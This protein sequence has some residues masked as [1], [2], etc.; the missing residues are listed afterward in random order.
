MSVTRSTFL[1]SALLLA[2]LG[3]CDR[4]ADLKTA[5]GDCNESGCFGC[6]DDSK[7]ACWPLPYEPCDQAGQ[8]KDGAVCTNHGCATVCKADADC[9]PAEKCTTDGFCAPT[10]AATHPMTPGTTQTCAVDADC[11]GGYACLNGSCGHAL[12]CGIPSLL[13][14][15]DEQCGTG[16]SCDSGA[17]HALCPSGAC[18]IGQA[19]NAGLCVDAAPPKAE[20]LIDFD[21]GPAHRCINAACHP[22][23]ATDSQCGRMAFCDAGVCRADMRAKA[24]AMKE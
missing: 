3:G 12:S 13:C 20:C 6:L 10:G 19:C 17:C 18:P 24:S 16:R 5:V 8:C 9:R 1:F 2:A 23:C 4:D 11:G 21:C 14:A 15:S 7:R 22:L